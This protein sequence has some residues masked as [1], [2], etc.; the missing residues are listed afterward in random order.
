MIEKKLRKFILP[1]ILATVGASSYTL[2]DIFFVSKAAGENGLAAM[3]LI[4]P[5]FALIY[6][7]SVTVKSCGA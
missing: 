1:S 7:I 4:A 6:A 2:A 5:I 3:N